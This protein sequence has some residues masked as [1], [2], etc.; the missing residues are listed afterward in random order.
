MH[1]TQ[2]GPSDVVVQSDGPGDTHILNETAHWLRSFLTRTH[3]DLGRKGA[4]CPFMEQS[5]KMGR[6][7]LSSVD[8]SGP[9]GTARLAAT[10]RSA[11]ARLGD[12]SAPDSVYNAFVM[13]PVNASAELRRERVLEVQQELKA[14]AVAAGKMVGEFFPGH[15]M[16]GIHSDTFRPLVSPHPVLAVRA[17]VVTD[18]LFLTFPAIPAAERLSYLTVWHGLFG[19]GT[20]GPWGE[21]YEKARAEAEREVREYA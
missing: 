2:D 14:E 3:P 8:V 13:V 20:A 15:P 5:L 19:E 21:I 1:L 16:R 12:R 7:A 17:M 6:T 10:A 4:V 18:I 11:L 9:R